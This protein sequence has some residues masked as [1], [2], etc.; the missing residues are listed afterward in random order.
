VTLAVTVPVGAPPLAGQLGEPVGV[1]VADAVWG[2]FQ[3]EEHCP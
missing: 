2:M 3:G 1:V